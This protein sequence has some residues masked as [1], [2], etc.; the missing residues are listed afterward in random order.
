MYICVNCGKKNEMDLNTT[1]K[2]QCS[3]CGHRVLRKAR[4]PIPKMVKAN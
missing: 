3:F 2:I 4:A 1:K